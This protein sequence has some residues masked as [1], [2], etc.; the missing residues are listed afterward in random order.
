MNELD[1]ASEQI[2]NLMIDMVMVME[3]YKENSGKI[4]DNIQKELDSSLNQQRKM[5]VDMVRDDILHH[6]ST[7]VKAYTQNMDDARKQMV[8]QVREF[9]TYLCAVKSEN[10]KIFRMTVLGMALTL[11]ML[12]LG[13]IALVFF[14]SNIISQKKLEADMLNRINSS[15]IVRCG[16]S[17]CAKTGKVGNNGYR[18]IQHRFSDK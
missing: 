18:V 5:I 10:Q 2:Q 4:V 12:V 13:G 16:D 6:A 7:Q 8:E 17:L 9:N 14:Y 3:K 11:T 15:D 1:R